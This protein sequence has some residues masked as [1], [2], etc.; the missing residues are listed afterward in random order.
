VAELLD[1]EAGVI[2]KILIIMGGFLHK[3]R[4]L[5][6]LQLSHCHGAFLLPNGIKIT[7]SLRFLS[8]RE[9]EP[10]KALLSEYSNSGVA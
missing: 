9:R 8:V 6:F 3:A 2:S 7:A 10:V 5:V 1:K 4:D